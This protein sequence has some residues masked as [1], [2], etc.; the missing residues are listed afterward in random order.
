MKVIILRGIPG[1][2]KST[3]AKQ[4]VNDA[5]DEWIRVNMDDIRIMLNGQFC[6]DFR[7]EN[8]VKQVQTQTIL[9]ALSLGKNVI[10]DNTHLTKRAVNRIISLVKPYTNDVEIKS[11]LDVPINVCI[12]RDAKR[13]KPVGQE[14][15]IKLMELY[16]EKGELDE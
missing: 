6:R 1:S 12:E 3:W 5:G 7:N 16:L 9:L 2:G 13:E 8:L 10:V 14:Q 11:F 15:I 4:Y